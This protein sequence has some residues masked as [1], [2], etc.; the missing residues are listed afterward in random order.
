[1]SRSAA[2]VASFAFEGSSFASSFTSSPFASASA[3]ESFGVDIKRRGLCTKACH[4]MPG[5]LSMDS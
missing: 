4:S 2:I 3:C 5:E 1:M